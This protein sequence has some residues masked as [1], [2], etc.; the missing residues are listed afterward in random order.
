MNQILENS[1]KKFENSKIIKRI[2]VY[3]LICIFLMSVISL[4]VFN[5]IQVGNPGRIFFLFLSL[6]AIILGIAIIVLGFKAIINKMQYN[7]LISFIAFFIGLTV[8]VTAG[9]SAIMTFVSFMIN[10]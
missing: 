1:I 7:L 9:Y 2:L 5:V 10:R 4:F 6:V 3:T 8:I